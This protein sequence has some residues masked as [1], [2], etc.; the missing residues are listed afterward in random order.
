MT[1][2]GFPR[3]RA[4]SPVPQGPDGTLPQYTSMTALAAGIPDVGMAAQLIGATTGEVILTAFRVAEGSNGLITVAEWD[5]RQADGAEFDGDYEPSAAGSTSPTVAW[6]AAGTGGGLAL[7]GGGY[8][9]WP[10]WLS[11]GAAFAMK[12][13]AQVY[14]E[15]VT[16]SPVNYDGA[17]AGIYSQESHA[18]SGGGALYTSGNAFRTARA[19]SGA[20]ADPTSATAGSTFLPSAA[21][22]W[23]IGLFR[24]AYSSTAGSEEGMTERLDPSPVQSAPA[25]V[26][27]TTTGVAD[28]T[29]M[30]ALYSR[31]CTTRFQKLHVSW[32]L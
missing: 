22:T 14:F 27:Q 8:L 2:A 6:R 23:L 11:L 31:Q 9:R 21:A 17:L 25:R 7:S 28:A 24:H 18:V 12:V 13:T 3:R 1:C 10:G 20:N 32:G 29:Q 4:A 5:L 26:A 15:S 16:A 30:P 19:N